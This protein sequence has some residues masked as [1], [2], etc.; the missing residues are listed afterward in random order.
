M[1]TGNQ[2]TRLY[3]ISPY[4]ISSL[5]R[6]SLSKTSETDS[7]SDQRIRNGQL[8]IAYIIEAKSRLS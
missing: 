5:L 8:S 1:K 3:N 6:F 4:S 2:N 7:Q